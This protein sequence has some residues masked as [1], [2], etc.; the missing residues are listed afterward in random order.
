MRERVFAAARRIGY[1][2]RL[3]ARRDV[4]GILTNREDALTGASSTA[5]LTR[6]VV[7]RAASRGLPVE[8]I[9]VHAA[10]LATKHMVTGLV[11]IGLRRADLFA[12]TNLP[13]VPRVLIQADPEHRGW[14]SVTWDDAQKVRDAVD[15]L[16]KCGHTQI[17][18]VIERAHDWRAKAMRE[19][20]SQA[21][22]AHDLPAKTA[23]TWSVE[24]ERP[25]DV[26]RA[27]RKSHVT[28]LLNFADRNASAL[29]D[30]LTNSVGLSVPAELSVIGLEDPALS[31]FYAPRL[32][33]ME[34]PLA[35]AAEEAIRLVTGDKHVSPSPR[36]LV[37]RLIERKSVAM[38]RSDS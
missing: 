11:G 3:M 9:P 5:R 38:P 17:G 12:I 21:W 14:Q 6:H 27:I 36:D 16:V 24:G 18:L 23:V 28:A 34:E 2:P 29:L 32:T 35:A 8:F 10:E 4:V 30:A 13:S 19:G 22:V 7:E 33:T 31:P 26:A 15:L 37:C 1:T 20:L 25:V